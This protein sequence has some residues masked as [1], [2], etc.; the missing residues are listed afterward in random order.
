MM[1]ADNDLSREK[2]PIQTFQIQLSFPQ[3]KALQGKKSDFPL[4]VKVF[5]QRAS[6]ELKYMS[7]KDTPPGDPKMTKNKRRRA[8]SFRLQR[9][10]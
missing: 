10:V 7:L 8:R 3:H 4:G 9:D 6:W 1:T 5:F 2:L